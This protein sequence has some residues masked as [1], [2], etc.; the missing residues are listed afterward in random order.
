MGHFCACWSE[1]GRISAGSAAVPEACH[2]L[3]DVSSDHAALQMFPLPQ[4]SCTDE[5]LME[6]V[7]GRSGSSGQ[8]ELENW[9]KVGS[10]GD[11]AD[12]LMKV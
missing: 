6:V 12:R 8:T 9:E 1:F 3:C 2:Y 11:N 10:L 4:Q 7:G 5:R